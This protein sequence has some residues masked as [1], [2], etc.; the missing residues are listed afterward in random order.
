ML[1]YLLF[2]VQLSAVAAQIVGSTSVYSRSGSLSLDVASGAKSE[3]LLVLF[4]S[5]TDDYLP[6]SLK[7]WNYAA[8]C[9]KTENGQTSCHEAEDCTQK[10]N[11]ND[12]SYCSAF[13]SGGG[14]RDLAT[15]VLTRRVSGLSK[16]SVKIASRSGSGKPSWAVL[17][18]LRDVEESVRSKATVSCDR[19]SQSVF[20][21]VN[22]Q[23]GDVL[24][25]SMCF[26][27]TTTD[28]KFTAPPGTETLAFVAGND[29]AGAV[30]GR[31][32]TSS[33]SSGVLTTGG[34]GAA[35]CKDALISLV[36]KGK[37]TTGSPP[38][39]SPTRQPTTAPP[40]PASGPSTGGPSC[41]A[42]KNIFTDEKCNLRKNRCPTHRQIRTKC[43]KTCCENGF[44]SFD[45]EGLIDD[46]QDGVELNS[47]ANVLPYTLLATLLVLLCAFTIN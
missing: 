34:A 8:S 20:P 44:A 28:D 5:R 10:F 27:D 33:G 12:G 14:G 26:D 32:F 23:A 40:T 47:S 18:V 41:G 17:T 30:W 42:K 37:G 16:V 24:L 22:G 35:N 3:D 25:L 1:K 43:A 29:E 9:Y 21:A 2:I 11:E 4:L 36:I 19:K 38:A 39:A 46:S 6:L 13:G 15:V 31:K 45:L 7:G